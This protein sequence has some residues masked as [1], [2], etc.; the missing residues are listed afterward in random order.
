MGR[1]AQV[2]TAQFEE[3]LTD[4]ANAQ[5]EEDFP[6][7]EANG[8]PTND[9]AMPLR[10]F[11]TATVR[12]NASSRSGRLASPFILAIH[13]SC[14]STDSMNGFVPSRKCSLDSSNVGHVLTR[15]TLEPTVSSEGFSTSSLSLSADADDCGNAVTVTVVEV[16]DDNG[17]AESDHV[18]R[19]ALTLPAAASNGFKLTFDVDDD[20][21]AS[22]KRVASQGGRG[23]PPLPRRAVAS[24]YPPPTEPEDVDESAEFGRNYS[25]DPDRASSIN[26][27]TSSKS[28]QKWPVVTTVRT[29]SRSASSA[30][31]L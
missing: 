12:R 4:M 30:S 19:R 13:A 7:D 2:A 15:P 22:P 1:L 27:R 20:S 18:P 8:D 21:A 26:R 3:L 6:A 5:M 9:E 16:A 24:V 23:L 31:V 11:S 28:S 25:A 10:S 29:R 14:D 17:I